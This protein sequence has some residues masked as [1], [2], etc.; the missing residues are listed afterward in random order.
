M[1]VAGGN[2]TGLAY[3]GTPAP[4][5]LDGME[6]VGSITEGG[7]SVSYKERVSCASGRLNSE[8][9][10][11]L[12]FDAMKWDPPGEVSGD[13][14]THT[15]SLSISATNDEGDKLD[16]K[17]TITDLK[18]FIAKVK[19]SKANGTNHEYS[20]R[21]EKV[22]DLVGIWTETEDV[23]SFLTMIKKNVVPS[24]EEEKKLRELYSD[25]RKSKSWEF[26]ADGTYTRINRLNFGVD[27]A[28]LMLQLGG[29]KMTEEQ[30]KAARLERRAKEPETES[31]KW[32]KT[33]D[34]YVIFKETP[35][36]ESSKLF[37]QMDGS[38]LSIRTEGKKPVL[39]LLPMK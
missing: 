17:I 35:P 25:Y 39:Q 23:E 34:G 38:G 13:N 20:V 16:M 32:E 37:D 24:P 12:G 7:M 29:L 4:Q 26:R 27:L 36:N 21:A 18:T 33:T 6:F 31:G 15:L 10:K 11:K 14:K 9:A 19:L 28:I 22:L 5:I 2:I 1:A 8:W 30:I 3:D